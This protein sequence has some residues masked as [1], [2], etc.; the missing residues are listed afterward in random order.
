MSLSYINQSRTN[1]WTSFYMIGTFIMKRTKYKACKIF[2]KF[3]K[4]SEAYSEPCQTSKMEL[5]AKVVS[6]FLK[7]LYLR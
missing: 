3:C 5:L 6:D 1:Q 7:T 4:G 2:V